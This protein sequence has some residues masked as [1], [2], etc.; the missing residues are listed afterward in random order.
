MSKIKRIVPYIKN[1]SSERACILMNCDPTRM[2]LRNHRETLIEK[3][4]MID[5]KFLD[6]IDNKIKKCEKYFFRRWIKHYINPRGIVAGL[7]YN[8]AREFGLLYYNSS[9]T[10]ISYNS[11]SK[12][13]GISST[14]VRDFSNRT[15]DI[16]YL[17]C[18]R[19]IDP[20]WFDERGK[21]SC[22]LME[23]LK[24]TIYCMTRNMRNIRPE[25]RYL[26]IAEVAKKRYP[27]ER[28]D[29]QLDRAY[30][31]YRVLKEIEGKQ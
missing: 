21:T 18:F 19:R 13:F 27:E 23:N 12:I 28:F 4:D 3:Y 2:V 16:E 10:G 24:N 6:D 30:N 22:H 29:R 31:W 25:E 9:R 15:K 8:K 26:R 14:T 20:D 11:L 1:I 7:I 5:N 17:S